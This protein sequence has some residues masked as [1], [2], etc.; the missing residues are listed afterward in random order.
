MAADITKLTT[1]NW[2]HERNTIGKVVTET[3]DIK[4]CIH[5]ICTTR[6]GKVPFM[7]EFGTDIFEAVG[8][9]S[10]D[11]IEIITAVLTKE[12]PLQ[13]PRCEITEITG[14][15]TA[16]GKVKITIYYKEKRTGITQKTE[17]YLN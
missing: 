3:D 2:Q 15:K 5:T 17:I 11:A 4:Q 16:E 8:E 7:P 12:I 9:N 14:I 10:D 1:K 13:E 6:K